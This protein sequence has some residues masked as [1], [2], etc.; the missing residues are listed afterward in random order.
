LLSS[1][2]TSIC[3]HNMVNFGPLAAE[4]DPVVRGTPTNFNG[5][6]VLA[7]LMHGMA[8]AKL[9]GVEQR[10]LPMFGRATI[11]LGIGPHSSCPYFYGYFVQARRSI[12]CL[13]CSVSYFLI[14]AALRSRC[15][16]CI[17]VLFLLL[18][19]SSPNLSGRRL[20]VYHTSTHG[21]AV[22]QI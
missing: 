7:A 18:F 6:L 3:P 4:I 20:D 14:M 17:F 5:F 13:H 19:Y 8:S 22:V 21:A 10:A 1:N 12:Y 11:T 16:H 9:C 2:M 15:G